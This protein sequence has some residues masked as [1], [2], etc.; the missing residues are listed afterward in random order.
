MAEP[1]LES[2]E[3]LRTVVADLVEE[4]PADLADDANLFELG[5]DSIALM[6]LVS[7]LRRDGAEV[8]FAALSRDPTLRAWYALLTT[9]GPDSGAAGDAGEPA[10]VR[11]ASEAA[12]L[13][14]MQ[15]AYWFGRGDT[16]AFGGVAAHLYTEFDGH[17][18]DPQRLRTAV[19]RLIARHPM[20]GVRVTEDGEQTVGG[21]AGWRGLA[22]QDLR[23][24]EPDEIERGLARERETRSHAML[25]LAA[26]EVF[27]TALSLLPGGRTRLH[28]D[29]DMVAADAVSYRILLADL[30]RH[31]DDPG[32]PAEPAGFGYLDYLAARAAARERSLT[33]AREHWAARLDTLP[34]A[35][36]LPTLAPGERRPRVTRRSIVLDAGERAALEAAA[37]AY[38]ITPAAAVAT[39]FAETLGAWSATPRFLLN[40]P[41]FDREPLHPDVPGLVGDFTSSVLLDVDLSTELPLADRARAVQSR[42]HADAAHAA[43]SGLEVLRDL[44]RRRGEPVLAPVVFT[45]ALRLGELFAPE[46]RDRFGDPVWIVSQGPQVLLDAQVTEVD[47]GLLVNWDLRADAFP[48]GVTDAMFDAFAGLV[49]RMAH[50]PAAWREPVGALLPPAQRAVRDRVN[51]TDEDP[52]GGAPRGRCL[53]EG[54]FAWAERDPA[55]PAVV[56]APGSVSYGALADHALRIA[57]TLVARGV[58]PGDLVAVRLPKGPGHAAALLGVLAA[59]AAYVPIGT[60]QPHARAERIRT[61]AGARVTVQEKDDG[62]GAVGVEVARSAPP[63]AAPVAPPHGVESTAYVIFTSGSTGEPKGVEVPH[64][65]AAATVDDLVGRFALGP[66][67]RTFGVSALDFDL[68]VFDLFA[69]LGSGGAVVLPA[70]EDRLDA[71]AW[72]GLVRDRRVTVLNCA[73]PLLDVLLS[74]GEPLGDTLRVVLLGGDRVGVDLPARLRAAVPGCRFAGLGGTTETAIHSTICEVTGDV[75]ADWACVPYG[76]PLRGVA[77]R[78][79][80]ARGRDAPDWVT[81]ELWIGGAGVARGYLGDA[82]RTA[83]R[84]VRHDGRRWYRTGD[85]ARYRPE[86]TVEFLGR[87]DDQV[88]VHGFRV[89]PGEVE[90]ALLADPAVAAA[91]V[92]GHGPGLLAAVVAADG[93]ALE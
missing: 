27:A 21:P 65:A 54:F 28:L 87:F 19:E 51:D 20:L 39:A 92:V 48:D 37:R 13:A 62:D 79:V 45:S 80:D 73:P 85:L 50:A 2:W 58:R 38:G 76:T 90:A 3:R 23:E 25:D 67:D 41:L 60:A 30:A 68:S 86:G 8:D 4:D 33:R 55:A 93:T 81:G 64:R 57:A 77:M 69:P 10:P 52:A 71:A 46:V 14:L 5:L 63:L 59:G 11:K 18:V 7:S 1:G 35:P 61:L 74:S 34:G 29:V 17:G 6:R 47:G 82:E 16:H 40:V 75:P 31:Y 70:E 44:G 36:E 22:V 89:E 24:A 53:H 42:L 88:S 32:R 66:D 84:F 9:H 91:T 15:H 56:T 12:P 26:G 83:D 49:R 78:V 43:Y 72:A